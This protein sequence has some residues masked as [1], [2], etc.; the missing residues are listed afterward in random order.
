[1]ATQDKDK[2]KDQLIN[3]L[4]EMRQ[5]ITELEKSETERKRAEVEL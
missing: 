3:E 1:M 2:T 4:M 5:R